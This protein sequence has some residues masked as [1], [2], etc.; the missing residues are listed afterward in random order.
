MFLANLLYVKRPHS[1][2]YLSY[3]DPSHTPALLDL[4]IYF[5]PSIYST[6][7]VLPLANF[8]PVLVTVLLTFLQSKGDVPFYVTD[9]DYSRTDWNGLYNHLRDFT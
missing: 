3:Q 8:D 6:L 1:D 4:F 5:D 7:V 2:A 9:F